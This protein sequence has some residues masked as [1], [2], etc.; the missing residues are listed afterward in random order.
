MSSG[1]DDESYIYEAERKAKQIYLNEEIIDSNYDPELFMLFCSERKEPNLDVWDF[2]ELQ[3]CVQDFKMV[4]RRGQ[5]LKDIQDAEKK[6]PK[7]KPKIVNPVVEEMKNKETVEPQPES[8]NPE[9]IENLQ[10]KNPEKIE[11]LQSKNPEKIENLQTKN[12]EKQEKI[13]AQTSEILENY[14]KNFK[15]EKNPTKTEEKGDNALKS[16]IFST[17]GSHNISQPTEISDGKF[18]INCIKLEETIL[19]KTEDL[20]FIINKP[21]HVVAGLLSSDYYLYPVMTLPLN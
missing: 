16:K 11:N 8:K 9:K 10:S 19:S 5:T 6:N 13:E 3:K 7:Q 20:K 17:E 2:E 15:S 14:S 12:S 18:L 4:Y 1:S 21:E